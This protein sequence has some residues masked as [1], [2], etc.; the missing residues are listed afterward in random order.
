M[1][2]SDLKAKNISILSKENKKIVYKKVRLKPD[3][4]SLFFSEQTII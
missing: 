3:N 2:F 4:A 1:I